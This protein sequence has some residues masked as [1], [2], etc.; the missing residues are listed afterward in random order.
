MKNILYAIGSL[1]W[2]GTCMAASNPDDFELFQSVRQN[3]PHVTSLSFCDR[4][5]LTSLDHLKYFPK[6]RSLRIESCTNIRHLIPTIGAL[7]ALYKL[8]WWPSLET[9]LSSLSRLTTLKELSIPCNS[10]KKIKSFTK[11]D[12]EV[13]NLSA[14]TAI[15]DLEEI[16]SF[17]ELKKLKLYNSLHFGSDNIDIGFLRRNKKLTYLDI[18]LSDAISDLSPV[19]TLDQ[20]TTLILGP[21]EYGSA[22]LD[23]IQNLKRLENLNAGWLVRKEDLER[24]KDLPKLRKLYCDNA[25]IL[26]EGLQ[27]DIRKYLPNITFTKDIVDD[28]W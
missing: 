21:M 19:Y 12:L 7:T 20:L 18:G 27:N 26:G 17:N 15:E 23:G 9:D 24:M 10:F 25:S 8:Y 16:G 6:L 22:S 13:L 2:I 28:T 4:P 1:L 3:Q 11:L 5:Q 14:S